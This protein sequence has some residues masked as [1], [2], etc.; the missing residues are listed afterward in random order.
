[1]IATHAWKKACVYMKLRSRMG[2][3]VTRRHSANATLSALTAMAAGVD[4][5][6]KSSVTTQTDTIHR[7]AAH[8]RRLRVWVTEFCS[9]I[10]SAATVC[11]CVT[12]VLMGVVTGRW[13]TH[14]CT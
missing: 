1:M 4:L 11:R 7:Q 3:M 5:R 6:R 12:T 2:R 13:Y 14:A 10:C 9:I 8:T